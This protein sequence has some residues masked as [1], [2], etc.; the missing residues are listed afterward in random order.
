MNSLMNGRDKMILNEI[1]MWCFG[2]CSPDDCTPNE[3]SVWTDFDENRI[4]DICDGIAD[5]L[6][7]TRDMPRGRTGYS[8]K[9]NVL[10]MIL[11]PEMRKHINLRGLAAA[12]TDRGCDEIINILFE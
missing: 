2:G 7:S 1:D 10:E 12:M 6:E 11:A 4:N 5:W 3:L 8:P 9:D